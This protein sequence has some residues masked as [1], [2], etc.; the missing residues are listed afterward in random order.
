MDEVFEEYSKGINF[1]SFVC[2]IKVSIF[3][4]LFWYVEWKFYFRW[5]NCL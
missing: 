5:I 4:F 3:V 1:C 2:R